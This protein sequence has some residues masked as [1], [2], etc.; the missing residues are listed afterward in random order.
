M[1]SK[2]CSHR[3]H[4]LVVA[5]L[6]HGSIPPLNRLRRTFI[7]FGGFCSC[8]DRGYLRRHIV[9]VAKW[10]RLLVVWCGTLS[11]RFNKCFETLPSFGLSSWVF[12]A[13]KMSPVGG[14]RDLEELATTGGMVCENLRIA[15][16]L[17]W[18]LGYI[19]LFRSTRSCLIGWQ[20]GYYPTI[21]CSW[22]IT[23][24]LKKGRSLSNNFCCALNICAK[25]DFWAYSRISLWIDEV[26]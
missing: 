12:W 10:R 4:G 17:R 18:F 24:G 5:F 25:V 2:D 26:L 1:K 23:T 9:T 22:F 3:S 11:L 20:F 19:G 16:K 15:G 7:S 21:F 13:C 8:W 6:L 14:R